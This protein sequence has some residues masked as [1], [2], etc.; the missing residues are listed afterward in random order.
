M[1]PP[2]KGQFKQVSCW[3]CNFA[4]LL[5]VTESGTHIVSGMVLGE[6]ESE[7]ATKLKWTNWMPPEVSMIGMTPTYRAEPKAGL[8]E[9]NAG[10]PSLETPRDIALA[11]ARAEKIE[12]Y[13][14]C[15]VLRDRLKALQNPIL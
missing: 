8:P 10:L 9:I 13:E 14:T 12:D 15:A 1:T 5:E 3:G 4:F 11:I 7:D 6:I 2:E